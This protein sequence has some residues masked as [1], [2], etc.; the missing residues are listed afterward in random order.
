MR[1]SMFGA[2]IRL[3]MGVFGKGGNTEIQRLKAMNFAERSN[4]IRTAVFGNLMFT[5]LLGLVASGCQITG[6][7]SYD[8]RVSASESS[9]GLQPN[10]LYCGDYHMSYSTI[11]QPFP[12][13]FSSFGNIMDTMHYSKIKVEKDIVDAKGNTQKLTELMDKPLDEWL[14]DTGIKIGQTFFKT[15]EK[16]TGVGMYIDLVNSFTGNTVSKNGGADHFK[17]WLGRIMARPFAGAS[18]MMD[19]YDQMFVT[20]GK[21]KERYKAE[22]FEDAFAYA[23]GANKFANNP[24]LSTAFAWIPESLKTMKEENYVRDAFGY[25]VPTYYS[26]V[27]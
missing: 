23:I 25:K 6:D 20:G 13:L 27:Q 14:L 5:A 8:K 22:G 2:P 24:I 4:Y 21:G 1:Y 9:G 12:F 15:A 7:M 17:I 10:S 16:E 18:A 11:S 19:I 3:G 26:R